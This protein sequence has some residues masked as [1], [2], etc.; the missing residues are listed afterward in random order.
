MTTN[1]KDPKAYLSSL[2]SKRG[3]SGPDGVYVTNL[4]IVAEADSDYG[5]KVNFR[6]CG[7]LTPPV[8]LDYVSWV[9]LL[10]CLRFD[11][12]QTPKV[13]S[14]EPDLIPLDS[15]ALYQFV[16]EGGSMSLNVFLPFMDAQMFEYMVSYSQD[17]LSFAA[18][19]AGKVATNVRFN[20]GY[21]TSKWD[22]LVESGEVEEQERSF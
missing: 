9:E 18:N 19:F 17:M 11:N 16:P 12:P 20:I 6:N 15:T 13:I 21:A 14:T 7:H 1:Y 4:T 3:N 22:D 10:V 2:I 8:G 5:Y